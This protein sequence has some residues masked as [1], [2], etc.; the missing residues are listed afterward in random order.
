M[1]HATAAAG[2]GDR[3]CSQ[4]RRLCDEYCRVH[5]AAS[6]GERI[7][8]GAAA[9]TSDGACD[10][11][12]GMRRDASSEHVPEGS[13]ASLTATAAADGH[14]TPW[15][16]RTSMSIKLTTVPGADNAGTQEGT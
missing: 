10:A 6:S 7:T 2:V 4:R 14:L 9:T 3:N 11:D 15:V 16:R 12:S 1:C 8:G 13:V 5:G